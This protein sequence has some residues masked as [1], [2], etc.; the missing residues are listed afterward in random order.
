M[1]RVLNDEKLGPKAAAWLETFAAK[2][3]ADGHPVAPP[4][5]PRA[6]EGWVRW[7][8]SILASPLEK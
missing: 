4:A 5:E 6:A 8:R 1:V 3:R 2:W 7:Y